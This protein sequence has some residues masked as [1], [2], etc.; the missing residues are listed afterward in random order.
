M[1]DY[2][3]QFT[4]VMIDV[5]TTGLDPCNAA[6]IQIGA[7]P[8]NFY[9]K[10]VDAKNMYK[11]SL[12]MPKSRFWTSNTQQ[13]WMVDNRELYFKIMETAQNY[14]AII[15]EFHQWS[16]ELGNSIRWWSKGFFDWAIVE[17]YFNM[18]NLDMPYNFRQAKDMRSFI[19]GLN[20]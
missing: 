13:F 5:E 2:D 8:F 20:G 3:E 19:A 11:R 9:T 16:M 15:H 10:E 17:S 7:V 4:D 6:I 14:Q 1:E 12:T 18:E